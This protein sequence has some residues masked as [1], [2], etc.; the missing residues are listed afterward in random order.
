MEAKFWHERWEKN[1]I[2]FHE[3][4]PNPIL[5]K[6]FSRLGLKKRARVF[7]PL[8][9]KTLDIGWLLSQGCRVAGAELSEIAVRQLFNELRVEPQISNGKS[10][11]LKKFSAPN[12]DIF[13]GDI[14]KVTR[15]K[16]GPIDAIYDRAAL[17][18]L[19]DAVRKR[20]AAHLLKISNRAPQLLVTYDYDQS[21]LAGPPFSISNCEL[22]NHYA[23]AYDLVL[24]NS[25]WLKGGLKGKCPAIENIWR[26][27]SIRL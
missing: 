23:K 11:G 12:V 25:Q 10:G 14:F 8:C 21:A 18:A 19:P 6:Y 5:L 16:L 3:R 22:V 13:V 26:L 27:T 4:K 7:V 1:E 17:V 20:Y 24:L 9:G 2:P 15:A